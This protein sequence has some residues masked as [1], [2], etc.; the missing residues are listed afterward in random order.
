MFNIVVRF[1]GEKEIKGFTC[2]DFKLTKP[3]LS[4][5][6][7]MCMQTRNKALEPVDDNVIFSRELFNTYY[8][9]KL[10]VDGALVFDG[11]IYGL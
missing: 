4:K 1:A 3:E 2:L 5:D 9:D 8:I 6:G 7:V 11:V 10:W